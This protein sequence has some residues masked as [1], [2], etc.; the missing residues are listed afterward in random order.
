MKMTGFMK[1]AA[2]LCMAVLLT[3]SSAFCSYAENGWKR[4]GNVW[5]YYYSNGKM[6]KNTWVKNGD[7]LFW[8]E[9]DGAMATSK[10]LEQDHIWFRPAS[11]TTPVISAWAMPSWSSTA[12]KTFTEAMASA[13]S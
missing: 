8:I 4:S 13:T 2:V 7:V 12:S 5:N 9:E 3:L 1:R 6:A 10:W 11:R